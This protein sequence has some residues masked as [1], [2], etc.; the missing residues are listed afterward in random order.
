MTYSG[1]NRTVLL[2]RKKGGREGGREEEGREGGRK[3]E[4]WSE[5]EERNKRMSKRGRHYEFTFHR[6]V[7][8]AQTCTEKKPLSSMLVEGC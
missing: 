5:R 2:P 6:T 3:E 7:A 4:E 1:S 8:H